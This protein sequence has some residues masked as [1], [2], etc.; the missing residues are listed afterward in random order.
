MRWNR[1]IGFARLFTFACAVGALLCGYPST[2][3]RV[4]E[5]Y[6]DV[7]GW[8]TDEVETER[9]CGEPFEMR[10]DATRLRLSRGHAARRHRTRAP[11]HGAVPCTHGCTAERAPTSMCDI[12][13]TSGVMRRAESGEKNAR[14]RIVNI[15]ELFFIWRLTISF[16]YSVQRQT[17][18]HT[19]TTGARP[20]RPPGARR[21]PG[22]RAP[23][24]ARP[25]QHL[26]NSCG[27]VP[28]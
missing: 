2:R 21:G 20:A 11:G 7:D 23:Y 17:H 27:P 1:S 8:L 26:T 12:R 13:L 19:Y 3:L 16:P 18:R 10:P 25:P 9:S 4:R 28:S 5:G 14:N 24:R 6:S 15:R 22:R